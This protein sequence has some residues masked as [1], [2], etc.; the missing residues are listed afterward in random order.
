MISR[1]TRSL[2]KIALIYL[3]A[4]FCI[5]SGCVSTNVDKPSWSES[6]PVIENN[7]PDLSGMYNNIAIGGEKDTCKISSIGEIDSACILSRVLESPLVDLPAITPA[8]DLTNTTVEIGK[9]NDNL[10]PVK[11]YKENSLLKEFFLGQ[12][13]RKLDCNNGALFLPFFGSESFGG[14]GLMMMTGGLYFTKGKDDSIILE[15][16]IIS[17]GVL[18]VIPVGSHFQN[19]Y[20]WESTK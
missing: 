7:C 19:W 1:I 12:E 10:I 3:L 15:I 8:T 9:L 4:C 20:K 18:L 6:E 11:I 17:G 2:L 5:L 14:Y 13:E 16:N